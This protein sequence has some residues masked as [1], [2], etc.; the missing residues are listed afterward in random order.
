MTFDKRSAFQQHVIDALI[1]SK[2]I[3]FGAIGATMSKF[4][5]RAARDGESLVHIINKNVIINC[6]W[7]VGPIIDFTHA[8]IDQRS[9][10]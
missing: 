6:G 3:D 8:E 10:G 2:A 7:P 4:G 9:R 5:E 1:E